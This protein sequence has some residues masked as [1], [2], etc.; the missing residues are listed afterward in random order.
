M[1][2]DRLEQQRE[3]LAEERAIANNQLI[4]VLGQLMDHKGHIE[5][6]LKML[7]AHMQQAINS[8]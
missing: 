8:L 5:E 6:R 2:N 4:V 7:Q 1:C 3:T